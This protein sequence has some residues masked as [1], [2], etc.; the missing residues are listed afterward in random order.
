M[1]RDDACDAKAPGLRLEKFPGRE[2]GSENSRRMSWKR[3]PRRHSVV[4]RALLAANRRKKRLVDH[5]E[6]S[7]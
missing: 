3:V 2:I 4:A 5:K 7:T 1:G 6:P